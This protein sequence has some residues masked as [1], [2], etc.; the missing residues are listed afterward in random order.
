M[1][2]TGRARLRRNWLGRL[3]VQIEY[4]TYPYDLSVGECRT[5]WMD[6][7]ETDLSRVRKMRAR[8]CMAPCLDL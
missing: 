7:K 3:V 2:W 4:R 5:G 8:A 1:D 6:A